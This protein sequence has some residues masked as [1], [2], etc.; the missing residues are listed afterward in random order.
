MYSW[1]SGLSGCRVFIV[2]D[3]VGTTMV[4]G[5]IIWSTLTPG[6]CSLGLGAVRCVVPCERS[7]YSGLV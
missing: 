2:V 7:A 3:D 6:F 4:P 1:G 5:T